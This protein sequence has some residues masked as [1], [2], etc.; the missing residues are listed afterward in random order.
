VPATC[1][2]PEPDKSSPHLSFY[3]LKIHLNIILLSAPGSSKWSLSLRVP[4]HNPENTSPPPLLTACPS[5]HI[6][7]DFIKRN[8]FG[9]DYGSPS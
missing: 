7:L 3:F 2:Y 4:H 6:L 8:I 1:P 9:E 5:H